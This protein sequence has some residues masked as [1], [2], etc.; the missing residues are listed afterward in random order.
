MKETF[1]YSDGERQVQ[2]SAGVE[3]F[4]NRLTSMVKTYVANNGIYFIQNQSLFFISSVGGDGTLWTSLIRGKRK[5]FI[6]F[7]FDEKIKIHLSDIDWNENDI[8]FQNLK[9]NPN[10][11]LLFIEFDNRRRYRINGLA[12]LK[13]NVIHIEV[14]QAF[15]NCPKYIQAR[16]FDELKKENSIT[17]TLS[18]DLVKIKNIV[19]KADTFT[20][21]TQGKNGGVD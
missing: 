8:L 4:A 18:L 9:E 5:N 3:F 16:A 2:K 10:I 11:G 21:G 20:M 14:L 13:E 15:P 1:N 12:E 6:Q 17:E 7:E 19:E